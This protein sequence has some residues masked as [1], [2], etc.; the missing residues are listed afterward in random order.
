MERTKTMLALYKT[1]KGVENMELRQAPVPQPKANEVL[2]EIK[3][4][5][6]CGTDVHIRHDQFPY[7][8][9]VIM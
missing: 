4:A 8:P 7:W 1:A 3:A 9:P 5:G 2:I 6:V